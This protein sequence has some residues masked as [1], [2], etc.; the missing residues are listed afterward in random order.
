MV[1]FD[2]DAVSPG[3]LLGTAKD[4]EDG[5]ELETE[6]FAKNRPEHPADVEPLLEQFAALGGD[7]LGLALA[8]IRPAFGRRKGAIDCSLRSP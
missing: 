5:H 4:V 1:V 7:A 6:D 8:A 3:D 2:D